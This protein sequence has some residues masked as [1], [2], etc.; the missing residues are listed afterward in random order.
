MNWAGGQKEEEEEE[1]EA[2]E[3]HNYCLR[4][5]LLREKGFLEAPAKNGDP[6]ERLS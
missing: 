1:E 2:Q 3:E 4:C 6:V 5:E